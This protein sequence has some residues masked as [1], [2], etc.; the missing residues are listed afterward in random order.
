M[1]GWGERWEEKKRQKQEMSKIT[2]GV[3][4]PV[5]DGLCLN[6]HTTIACLLQTVPT[7]PGARKR[8]RYPPFPHLGNRGQVRLRDPGGTERYR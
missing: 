5:W 1:S 4:P 2:P 3:T 6:N 8:I 7:T